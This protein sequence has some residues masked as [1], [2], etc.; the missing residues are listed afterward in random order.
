MT[1][2]EIYALAVELATK[3]MWTEDVQAKLKGLSSTHLASLQKELDEISKR[4]ARMSGYVGGR[5]GYGCGDKGHDEANS[6][7]I[8]QESA[9]AKALGYM[10]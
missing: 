10:G 7:G 6:I 5:G 3:P 4:A 1:Q 2:N 8:K 9:A